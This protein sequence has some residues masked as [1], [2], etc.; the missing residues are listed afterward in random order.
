MER[1]FRISFHI[2]NQTQK[3]QSRIYRNLSDIKSINRE[4]FV[5]FGK[6]LGLSYK[7][8]NREIDRFCDEY[9]ELDTLVGNS[10]LSENL[11]NNWLLSFK[12]RRSTLK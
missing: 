5:E 4:S 7:I 6:R 3:K 8:I 1:K 2:A 11:K 10:F 12:Y 9:A